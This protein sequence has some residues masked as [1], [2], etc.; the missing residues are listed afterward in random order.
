MALRHSPVGE[1]GVAPEVTP[2][3]SDGCRSV[4]AGSRRAAETGGLSAAGWRFGA[5]LLRLLAALALASM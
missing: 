1:G 4:A 3:L 5:P 2:G